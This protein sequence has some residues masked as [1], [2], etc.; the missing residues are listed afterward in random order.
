LGLTWDRVDFTRRTV[1]ISW[2]LQPLPHLTGRSGALRIPD[3]YEHQRLHGSVCLVRPKSRQGKRIVPMSPDLEAALIRWR[4]VAWPSEHDLVWPRGPGDGRGRA[5]NDDRADWYA[6][7]DLA[8][9]ARPDGT[10][11]QLHELRHTAATVMQTSGIPLEVI[12][13]ILGH[14][15]AATTAEYAHVDRSLTE[16]AVRALGAALAPVDHLVDPLP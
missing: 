13:L 1:D 6:L 11:Y 9:V 4:D 2:Q 10:R 8:G 3:D 15:I 14:S 16:H 12:R 5:A 7:Q